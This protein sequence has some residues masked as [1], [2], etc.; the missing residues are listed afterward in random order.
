VL[1]FA[2]TGRKP[3]GTGT[4]AAV[5]DRVVH[6]A[7]ALEEGP[8]EV[9][10]LIEWCLARDSGQRPAAA[11]LLARVAAAQAAMEPA[12]GPGVAAV[13]G[14]PEDQPHQGAAR[15]R[16]RRPL[17]TAS[18]V[19]GVLL[20]SV[21]GYGLTTP[22]QHRPGESALS[23]TEAKMA[24]RPAGLTPTR[25][26]ALPPRIIA[27]FSYQRGEMMYF[28]ISFSDPDHDAAGFGF[29]GANGSDWPRRHYSFSSPGD[30]IIE[31]N[32]VAYPLDQGCGTGLEYASDVRAWIY[33]TAG[34]RSKPVII[35]L[36]CST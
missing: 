24:A 35:H 33:D 22:S 15:R 16:P 18:A 1:A 23:E 13:Q 2:A 14:P 21:A 31:A 30:G 20:A 6:G 17:I 4:A 27:T 9:R 25:T 36:V 10:P 34:T 19:A 5:L 29:V 8:A 32:R 11:A 3:F 28:V 7:P 26:P 12:P